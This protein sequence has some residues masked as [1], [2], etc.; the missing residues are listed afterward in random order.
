MPRSATAAAAFEAGRSPASA[1]DKGGRAFGAAAEELVALHDADLFERTGGKTAP[2][3][4]GKPTGRLRRA[5]R[6]SAG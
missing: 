6:R 2:R 3:V 5:A 1:D 4:S